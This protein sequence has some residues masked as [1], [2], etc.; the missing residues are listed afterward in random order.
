MI[1]TTISLQELESK[2]LSVDE[3]LKIL[4]DNG[5]KLYR[6]PTYW[7]RVEKEDGKYNYGELDLALDFLSKNN[8]DIILTIGIKSLRRPEFHVPEWIN[9]KDNNLSKYLPNSKYF[10]EKAFEYFVRTF[11]RYRDNK[12][13]KWWQVENEPF[14]LIP[15]LGSFK[16]SDE[17]IRKEIQY[18]KENDKLKRKIIL[19][20]TFPIDFPERIMEKIIPGKRSDRIKTYDLADIIGLDIYPNITYHF[21]L[22]KIK[23]VTTRW[24][25]KALKR[26]VKN[27]KKS[28][29][30]TEMQAESWNS[31]VFTKK[32]IKEINYSTSEIRDLFERVKDIGFENILFWGSEFWI[33][34]YFKGKKEWLETITETMQ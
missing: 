33:D 24:D 9:W 8:C 22:G 27:Q 23:K 10:E 28:V 34:E 30:I 14:D 5:I 25:W 4:I 20:T 3:S 6:I 2:D 18:I 15:S 1:G 13:I 31:H 26:F 21:P 7:N 17:Y 11:E 29:W 32:R 19:T 16:I 12:N